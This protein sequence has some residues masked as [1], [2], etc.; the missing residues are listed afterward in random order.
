MKTKH[1]D[2]VV[3]RLSTKYISDILLLQDTVMEQLEDKASLEKLSQDEFRNILEGNGLMIGAFVENKLFAIRALL[4]PPIDDHHLG[5]F[6]G[7]T[8]E[9]LPKVI[10]QEVSLVHPEYRGN[11]M[12]QQLAHLI[13]N[14]L[15]NSQLDFQYVCCTV[16]PFNIPSL[17]DKFNQR[18]KIKALEKVYG[19]KLRYVF[20]KDLLKEDE[21]EREENKFIPMDD[22][23]MQQRLL[24][25][26]WEGIQLV[27]NK[28]KFYI[29]YTKRP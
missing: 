20:I 11:R 4:I 7:L 2:F 6:A 13:M 26:E 28:D 25:S 1:K 29:Q 15:E 22:I 8:Q 18:M 24:A 21:L 19:E 5:R 27:V 10:Y 17:K 9:E 16:A 12:Q 14:E 23:E 3:K